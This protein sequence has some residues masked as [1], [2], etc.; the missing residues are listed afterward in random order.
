[1]K[2]QHK[3][4]YLKAIQDKLSNYTHTC[5]CNENSRNPG[6]QLDPTQQINSKPKQQNRI[7]HNIPNKVL[8]HAPGGCVIVLDVGEAFRFWRQRGVL[9]GGVQGRRRM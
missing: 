9:C 1:M 8:R 6:L 5:Y 3:A 7:R 2:A 4:G